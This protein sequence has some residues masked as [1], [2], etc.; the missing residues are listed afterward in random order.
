[1]DG[2][3][4]DDI[5]KIIINSKLQPDTTSIYFLANSKDEEFLKGHFDITLL[6][7]PPQNHSNLT[8]KNDSQQELSD[9]KFRVEV[10]FYFIFLF[11]LNIFF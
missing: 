7:S 5:S 2:D 1:M 3:E 6:P 9:L 11:F 8:I 10:F 4:I